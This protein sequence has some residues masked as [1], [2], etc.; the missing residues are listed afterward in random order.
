MAKQAVR[1]PHELWHHPDRQVTGPEV[2]DFLRV[3][4]RSSA[5]W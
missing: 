1:L 5:G 2:R 3:L 4:R